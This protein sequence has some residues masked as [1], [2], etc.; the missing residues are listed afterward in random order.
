[1]LI[2]LFSSFSFLKVVD[3]FERSNKPEH[4]PPVQLNVCRASVFC[5]SEI[6]KGLFKGSEQSTA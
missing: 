2:I 5:I 6:S 3:P 1:L 4:L